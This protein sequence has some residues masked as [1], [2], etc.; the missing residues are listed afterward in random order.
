MSDADQ[1]EDGKTQSTQSRHWLTND[2]LAYLLNLSLIIIV[3]VSALGYS[4]QLSGTLLS[5][6]AASIALANLWAFGSEAANK[7]GEML[8][9]GGN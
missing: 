1:E 6:Y 4:V 9:G 7:L 3:G 2:G 8:N 5:V